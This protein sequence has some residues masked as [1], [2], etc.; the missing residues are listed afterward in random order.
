MGAAYTIFK[1]VLKRTDLDDKNGRM[2]I[3]QWSLAASSQHVLVLRESIELM[4]NF[5]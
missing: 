2:E 5:S 3:S 4:Y 1:H